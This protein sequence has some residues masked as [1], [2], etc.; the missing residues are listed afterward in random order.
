MTQSVPG[1]AAM[2]RKPSDGSFDFW[3]PAN[4]APLLVYLGSPHSA[5]ITGRVFEASGG[6]ISLA[7]GWRTGPIRDKGARWDAAELGPVIDAL[8]AEQV[9]PQP[10]Y[11]A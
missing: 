8:I 7:D 10:V 11:G 4:V 1:M 2:V 9:A 3:D 6:K 5:H